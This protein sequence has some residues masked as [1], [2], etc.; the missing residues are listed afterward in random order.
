MP[1]EPPAY[2]PHETAPVTDRAGEL[3][4]IVP[5]ARRFSVSSLGLV[6]GGDWA[7]I[8]PPPTL[9]RVVQAAGE[10]NLGGF[11]KSGKPA[12]GILG[13]RVDGA[14]LVV[15][16][17]ADL[18]RPLC[19]YWV[20]VLPIRAV[21]R[22]SSAFTLLELLFALAVVGVLALIAVPS[23][24]GYVD[25]VNNKKAIADLMA[26]EGA[27]VKYYTANF[28]YPASLDALPP[29]PRTDPWGHGYLYLNI[30]DG[31]HG[32]MGDVRKDKNLNPVN[33]DFDL[34]SMGKDGETA[35][36]FTNPKSHD[37]VV[38]ARDGSFVGLAADF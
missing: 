6:P 24:R 33:T 16:A 11:G 36:P 20:A 2:R 34:Y 7:G 1:I 5:T 3:A 10:A 30:A 15:A 25:R 38:R 37:D 17:A 13:G 26:I 31:G 21:M 28:H 23:Y 19:L 32:V 12:R 4:E 14:A 22:P 35:K 8:E 18:G 9:R 29:I 27:I